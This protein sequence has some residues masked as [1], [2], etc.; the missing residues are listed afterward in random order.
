MYVTASSTAPHE[1]DWRQIAN[2]TRRGFTSHEML[3]NVGLTHMNGRVYDP[4]EG[5]FIGADPIVNY[6][7]NVIEPGR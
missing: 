2:T 1:G 4:G 5:V 3:D 6:G 7:A